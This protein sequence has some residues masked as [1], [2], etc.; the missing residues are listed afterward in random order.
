MIKYDY[1]LPPNQALELRQQGLTVNDIAKELKIPMASLY[2]ILNKANV[3]L[4]LSPFSTHRGKFSRYSKQRIR[5]RWLKYLNFTDSEII[6][7]I[8][9]SASTISR[10]LHTIPIVKPKTNRGGKQ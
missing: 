4:S 8:H 2:H 1:N 6:E 9:C 7:M 5:A 10:A 3:S